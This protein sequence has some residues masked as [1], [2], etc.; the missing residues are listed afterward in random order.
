[1]LVNRQNFIPKNEG[2][3]CEAC[4]QNVPPAKGTFRNHC[5]NCLTAK[6]V[7]KDTPGDRASTCTGLMPTIRIEG[8]DPDNLDLMQQCQACGHIQRNRT[9]ADDN[10]ETIFSLLKKQTY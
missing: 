5:P 9:A 7:D 2:F 4:G 6:H 3:I 10:K 8:T 1:M